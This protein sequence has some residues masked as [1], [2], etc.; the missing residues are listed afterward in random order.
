MKNTQIVNNFWSK[1]QIKKLQIQTFC[2]YK[3][4]NEMCKFIY[5]K[6]I[7]TFPIVINNFQHKNLSKIYC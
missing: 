5:V 1:K 6:N 7:H 2:T 3:P 4:F